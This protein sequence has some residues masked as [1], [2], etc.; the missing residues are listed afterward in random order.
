MRASSIARFYRARATST[1]DGRGVSHDP[2]R[3]RSAKLADGR[4]AA[5]DSFAKID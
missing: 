2:R 5:H 4:R 1:S 3:G